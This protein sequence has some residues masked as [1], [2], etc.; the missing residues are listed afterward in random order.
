MSELNPDDIH[1]NVEI[2]VRLPRVITALDYHDFAEIQRVIQVDLGLSDVY[3][4][5]V[6]FVGLE[7]VGL[8][9]MDTESHNQ[10]VLELERY[11]KQVEQGLDLR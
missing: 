7:Y 10:L 2:T 4:T 9:H 6:G 1:T 8:I 5:E 11:Y 3:V